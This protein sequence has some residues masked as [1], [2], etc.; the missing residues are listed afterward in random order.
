MLSFRKILK[1]KNGTIVLDLGAQPA[2]W[3]CVPETLDITILNR[4]GIAWTAHP[5]HHKIRYV[6]GDAC[7][8]VGMSE[9][10]FDIVFSNIVIEHIGYACSRAQFTREVRRLGR[11]YWALAPCKYF[12]IEPPNGMPFWWFHPERLRQAFIRRWKGT[13]PVWTKMVEGTDIV[14]EEMR[15]AFTEADIRLERFLGLSKSYAAVYVRDLAAA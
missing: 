11:A 5:S 7:D 1:I 10:S 4:P 3:D 14:S 12:P 15:G 13:L 9:R 8:V 2:I 6:E